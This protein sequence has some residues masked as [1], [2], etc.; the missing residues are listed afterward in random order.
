MKRLTT[1]CVVFFTILA[2]AAVQ[3][4]TVFPITE[5]AQ[6]YTADDNYYESSDPGDVR[7]SYTPSKTGY[8]TVK[9]S[10]EDYSFYRYLY[11]YGEDDSFS[12]YFD[13]SS[14]YYT[15]YINF[16]CVQGKTYYFKVSVTYSSEYS[17]TFTIWASRENVSIVTTQGKA[18]QDTVIRG[19]SLTIK[20]PLNNGEHFV[21]W[22]V[23]FGTATFDDPNAISTYIYPTSDEVKVGYNVKDGEI[24]TLTEKYVPYVYNTNGS[25]TGYGAYGIRTVYEPSETGLYALVTKA[26][27]S[28]Y[29]YSFG[30]D[31]TFSTSPASTG[32]SS[33]S[34]SLYSLTAGRKYYFLLNQSSTASYYMGDTISV[35]MAR[36]FKVNADTAGSGYAYVGVNYRNYDSSYVANDTVPLSASSTYARFEKWEKVSGTC[37]I[38]DTNA[39]RTG[40][41]IESD[42]KVRAV[43]K[44]GKMYAITTTPT[45]YN[46][47]E[48]FFGGTLA[49]ISSSPAN[50]VRLYFV[51]PSD[52]G[53]IINVKKDSSETGLVRRYT[54]STFSS[55]SK[56]QYIYKD[57][58]AD[59]LLLTAGDSV[60][61][62]VSNYYTNDSLMSFSVSYDSIQTY[63]LT[64]ETTSSRCSTSVSSQPVFKGSV[65]S[66][67]G[68]AKEGYRPNGWTYVSGTHK[69]SDS[70]AY[71]IG[72]LVNED[73]KI[74]LGCG[75]PNLIDVTD[76]EK[77]YVPA[78]DFYEVSP[79]YGMR[80]RF[81]AP[82]AGT[83]ILRFQPNSFYGSYYYYATDNTFTTT[84]MSRTYTSAKATFVI[85]ATSAGQTFYAKAV[86]SSSYY[87][88]YSIGVAALPVAYVKIDGQTK[89]DTVAVGDTLYLSSAVLDEGEHFEK[90]T[91]VSGKGTFIDSTSRSS[92][93]IPG[94][95]STI[96]LKA[97][98]TTPPIYELTD[99]YQRFLFQEHSTYNAYD[100]YGVRTFFEAPDS[101]TYAIMSKSTNP[102]YILDYLN[103][104]TF[105]DYN[106]WVSGTYNKLIVNLRKGEKRYVLL[107]PYNSNSQDTIWAKAQKTVHLYTDT[108]GIGYAY[109]GSS[110]RMY[111]SS[112]VPQDSAPVRAYT[113][114]TAFRF[115]YWSVV[116][117]KCQIVDSTKMSTFIIPETDCKVRANFIPGKVYPI[118]DVATKYTN[119]ESY[120][121]RSALYG[122][123]F[124]FRAPTTGTYGIVFTSTSKI[125]EEKYPNGDFYSYSQRFNGLEFKVDSVSLNAGDSLFYIVTNYTYADTVVPFW[126]S[127]SQTKAAI[128][129][130]A[131]S[132]GSVEPSAG[133]PSAWIGA[134]YPI[135]ANPDSNFRFDKWVVESGHGTVDDPYAIKTVV[136]AKDSIKVRAY[137][138]RGDIYPLTDSVQVFNF[139]KHYFSQDKNSTV[140]FSWTPSDT[141]HYLLKLD[142]I[143]AVC[144]YYGMDSLFS[145]V[146]E[147]YPIN[148]ESYV[149]IQGKP[150]RTYYFGVTDSVKTGTHNVNFTAQIVS[151]KVLY[152]E[153]T[154]GRAVP[155]DFVYLTPG[156]DTTVYVIPYG[157]YL[158]DSWTRVSG[159]VTIDDS[160]SVRIKVSPQSDFSHIRANY[161]WDSTA[162]PELKITNLDLSNHPSICAQVSVVDK[163]TG[164]PIVGLDSS[165]YLLFQDTTTQSTQTTT[166]Q[167]I[168]GVSVA[169]VVDESGSMGG[170]RMTTA[171]NAIRQFINEMGP[172]DRTA[173]VGFSGGSSARVLQSM[174]SDKTLLLKAVDNLRAS[175][176]TNINTGAKL[177]VQ[178]VVGETNPT[179]VI[180]FSDG[181][182]N[183]D[184]TTSNE[185]INL[186]TG[187]STNIYTIALE[188]SSFDV[189][190][191]LADGT[192]GTFTNA[193]SASQLTG[194]Y[195]TIRSTVQARYVLCYQ[196]PDAVFDGDS[197]MVEIKMKFMNKD[198]ADTAYWDEDAKPPVVELTPSTMDL[199]GVEQPQ[200]K[201]LTLAVY[202]YSKSTDLDVRLYSREVNTSNKP[203]A[204][205]KMTRQNDSLWS[206]VIPDNLVLYPGIDFYVV[207]TDNVSGLT[208]KTPTV[209]NPSKEPYTIPVA[210]DVPVV[211][212]DTLACVDTTGGTGRI[213]FKITD[214]DNID[215]AWIYYKD[216][217]SVLFTESALTE[218][219]GSWVAYV[220]S[221]AFDNGFIEFYVRAIDGVGASVRWQKTDNSWISLCGR[222]NNVPNIVDVI[223]IVNADSGQT[224]IQ[225]GTKKLN[226]TLAT[227]DFTNA[228]DTVS[229]KLSCLIS[230]DVESNIKLVEKSSGYYEPLSFIPKDEK[231]ATKNDGK[232]SCIGSDTLVAEYK[233]PTFGDY[234][235]DTVVIYLADVIDAIKI[236]NADSSKKIVR[237]TDKLKLTLVTE[238]FTA[239]IDTVKA[240][241]SCLVSGDVEN[242]I[243]L[244]EKRQGYYEPVNLISKNEKTAKKDDGAISCIGRDTLVAEYF[245][246]HFGGY[247]RDTV[248]IHIENIVD[249]VKIVNADT[250]EKIMRGTDK[251]N[252]SVVTEDFTIAADTVKVKLSCL[253]S[254]DVENNIELV[255]T[256]AGYYKTVNPIAK[257][258]SAAVN[259]DG[260]ISCIGLDTLVAE[261]KDPMFGDFA[262]DT[263][264]LVLA[265]VNDVIRIV[266]ADSTQ[267]NILRE[268]DKLNLTLKTEDF[269]V[270]T[271]TVKAKLSCLVS[272]DVEND[273][274][275]V[276]KRSGYYEPLALISKNEDTAVKNDGVISCIGRDTLVAEYEDPMFGG[277]ARDKVVIYIPEVNDVI[278]IVNADSA[279]KIVRETDKLNLTLVTE[280]FTNKVDTVMVKLSCLASGD[281]EKNIKLV[282]Q[283]PGY[284]EIL[285]PIAK[286]EKT[287]EKNDGKIS[288]DGRDTLVAEYKDP[289]FGTY[290][291]DRVVISIT[292]VEDDIKIV[293]A[294]TSKTIMRE[295]NK[296]KVTLVTEDFTSKVDT[297]MVKLSCLV[298]GDIENDIELIEKK[299]GYYEIRNLISKDEHSVD[300]DD[301]SIS[302]KSSDTLVVE[303]K[304]P[305][306][307][308]H[309]RDTVPITTKSVPFS[310]KFL[311][312][313]GKKDLDSVETGEVAKFRLRLTS[314]SKS[315]YIKDTLDVLLLTNKGDSLWVKAVETDV[316]SSTFEYK[317]S[318][319]FVY[320]KEDLQKTDLDAL[321]DMKSAYNRVKITAKVKND[322]LG[323][324][325]DSLVV[326]SNYVPASVAE[327]YDSN[328]D[329]KADSIR[330]HFVAPNK[331]GVEG[332]DTLYWNKAGG[333]WKSV[334]KK[335]LKA[336]GDG[337]W[338]E[339]KLKE[340]FDYGAT[341]PDE[342]DVP[343]LRLTKPK[344]GFS[345]R[346]ELKDRVG[347]VPVKAVKRPGLIGIEE[348]LECS[349]DVP[350]D[351]LEITLSEP[352]KTK[353]KEGNGK[354]AAWKNLFVYSPDCKDTVEQ[355]LNILKLI[356][357][358][359]EGLVW[360]FVLGDFNVLTDNCIRTNPKSSYFDEQKNPMGRGGV[361][362]EGGNGNLYLYEVTPTPS[363]SGLDTKAEWIAPG[364]HKWSRVP[365]SLSVIRVASIMPYKADVVIYD[366]FSNIVTSFTREFGYK[367]E[368][369]EKIRENDDN[370][371][372]T[373]FL[374]WNNRSDKGRKVGTGVFIWRIDFKFKD[375]HSEFRLVKTGVKRKK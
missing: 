244:V 57:P 5:T 261:Y 248:V 110:S 306:F 40:V 236:V 3:H 209:T 270:G 144:T 158:F 92:G 299:S 34:R 355:P 88:N 157:G 12:T 73:T 98:K 350:P 369:K 148:G 237:E 7:F 294:D 65:V 267:S 99:V 348:Y 372:K 181:A 315:I 42:C 241:L 149:V 145:S 74:R 53:Y 18:K 135:M 271:D 370:R 17:E 345:Q 358:D 275:L 288:C 374:H 119:V 77:L 202:V 361:K 43:F 191:T 174:T 118:T 16:M 316:Y 164:R 217:L 245:D 309:A 282:E 253:A 322:N 238:D 33:I 222:K 329:G 229:V 336:V 136:M 104:G 280:D 260:K 80:F 168:G 338:Y 101:G 371:A 221:S 39:A 37:K 351:T 223:K 153:S 84:A 344:G 341:A 59:T 183:D 143:K 277:H 262:R 335:R 232:I 62:T 70:S 10:Y 46:E 331:D 139:Q 310:Y 251:L 196:S 198:I 146:R 124:N 58:Y 6:T 129:L 140:L 81:V 249:A 179:T 116:S 112:Y 330:I 328:K 108:A 52:G 170:N 353:G 190:K 55:Y 205:Y 187:L 28:R 302:C 64:V 151:P 182:N 171:Q 363:V 121:S 323:K 186:A 1:L 177:G 224:T 155:S 362:V 35:R 141:N 49:D 48:H 259:D 32:H 375:G 284:Y 9:S 123:R 197:H 201:S 126:V 14:G 87:W 359:S 332:I 326:F 188:T 219:N 142:S 109:V 128:A 36:T 4:G 26:Y 297:V 356:D 246:S 339:G 184:V 301:G 285:N 207:A 208:G 218:T 154:R 272:G 265:D 27:Y 180:V 29:I 231:A 210:T 215:S 281:V 91:V 8:C 82:A 131:D 185:V 235:R 234:A 211:K 346:V 360:T 354:D 289:L 103:D 274:V 337:S 357:K 286:N 114:S 343:Y 175:G 54:S 76:K 352:I 150:G 2:H 93:F 203:F 279:K 24:Y 365:D 107:Y 293:N 78:N 327:I 120:Y 303:Y 41:V 66:V 23:D 195:T 122:T 264:V 304:D 163:N 85:T 254:G 349:M 367:G 165:D 38:L 325:R 255:E 117:G 44:P 125:S 193:P 214:S 115:G 240:K 13:Y 314:F 162:V 20:A 160:S 51:A 239:E 137:F 212:L 102:E 96:E 204:A 213:S 173:I 317:G 324:K 89:T 31:A 72:V 60:F 90:W 30:E 276:E 266:N 312:Y 230:G 189:L 200:R 257:N 50:G 45:K 111:D 321:F 228:V 75:T 95:A 300:I 166:I 69:F 147:V 83:Y 366:A 97:V 194:I 94:S 296:L 226:L 61:Y 318:F 307:G 311:E 258:E 291:Y 342:D 176:N 25:M 263:V 172:Y 252:L 225:R 152:I 100:F 333:T 256:S 63:K 47:K 19:N 305:V 368:M 133:Y 206:Y 220:P 161:V 67:T 132:N 11:Y 269:S 134:A 216:S 292:E 56:Y 71:S 68:Y 242:N 340:A 227:E 21:D 22:Y 364:E 199:V 127:Y 313:A 130:V 347:A 243:K 273:I 334:T 15:P 192:G 138:R 287:A 320:E 283:R 106:N 247:A 373:G 290:A 178:Q 298:S 319:N 79:D 86:P 250:T 105:A 278:K 308:N 113:N 167:S 268:T 233:D 169:L 159:T 156:T 295:T